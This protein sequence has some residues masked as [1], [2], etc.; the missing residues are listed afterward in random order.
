M[1]QPR[2]RH[3]SDLLQVH[4]EELEFLW[5]RRRTALASREL[6]ARDY[7][8]LN[9]RIEAHIQGM[10]AVPAALPGLLLPRLIES[11]RDAVFAAACPL[12][13]LADHT[14]SA[15]VKAF[16]TA[17]DAALA[18]IRD[19]LSVAPIGLA[20]AAV[21]NQFEKADSPHAVAAAVVLANQRLLNPAAPRLNTLLL[22]S[23]PAVAELAWLAATIA[24]V[25]D[26]SFLPQRPFR[27]ALEQEAPKVRGA[28]LRA[29]AWTGQEWT[30]PVVRDFAAR[31]DQ[32]ALVW[33]AAL[34]MPE[35]FAAFSQLVLQLPSAEQRCVLLARFG[36]PGAFDLVVSWLEEEDVLAAAAGEAFTRITGA[37]IRGHRKTLDVAADA[38]EFAREFAPDVWLPDAA[39]ARAY[40]KRYGSIIAGGARWRAGVDVGGECTPEALARVDLEA[41]WDLCARA[42]LAGKPSAAPPP[43]H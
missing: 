20:T 1:T 41:R 24:D 27:H 15:V 12:L 9:E 25:R 28:A 39:K 36:H 40:L 13:R 33:L 29:A 23:E 10:L 35:D 6:T 42:A 26:P 32:A 18:G 7:T 5:G 21:Q 16:A 34:G 22:E 30:L 43:V 8:E 11:E 37:D 4:L 3:I 2:A 14:T 17:E 19:A 31:A 38:D